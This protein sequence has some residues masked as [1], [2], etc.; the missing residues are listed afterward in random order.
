MLTFTE[1]KTGRTQEVG[2]NEAVRIAVLR[3]LGWREGP[4]KPPPVATVTVEQEFE[5]DKLGSAVLSIT[6]MPVGGAT[7]D[8][9][10]ELPDPDDALELLVEEK[11]TGKSKKA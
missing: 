6:E 7:E 9:A 3:R 4:P 5:P 11:P 2:E 1:P 10:L 8:V